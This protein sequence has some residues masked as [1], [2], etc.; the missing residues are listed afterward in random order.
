MMLRSR[1]TVR[2]RLTALY[3][4]LFVLSAMVLLAITNGVGSS[5][6]HSTRTVTSGG[7]TVTVQV[8]TA[9]S[10]QYLVGS[11]IALGVMLVVSVVAGWV[12]AGRVLRPLRQMTTAARRI[13]ASN[14]HERLAIDGPGDELKHL[15]DTIDALLGRL[16]GAF[17]AQ[18]RFVA[19]A[20]HELRTPL[21]TM[22][23]SLDVAVA[24]PGPVPPET[25]TLAGQVRAEL[26]KADEL[27][28]GLLVLARAPLLRR[29]ADNVI[30][31]AVSHNRDGGW[32]RITTM[33]GDG[34]ARLIIENGGDIL[35]PAQVAGLAQPFR[36]LGADR[37]GS[38]DGAGLGLS[39]VAAITEAHRG[40]LDLHAR[41]GGGLKVTITLPLA[42][43]A[44]AITGSQAGVP[45]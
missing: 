32:I 45:A 6:S 34:A 26:N 7:Q 14:L 41:P 28:E 25:I 4:I 19:N 15:A 36:R 13:S 29:M 23:V 18:R 22:R 31:N 17:A 24:K 35:D 27:L 8:D 43:R 33:A 5:A 42:P 39:I 38:D 11:A 1:R 12:V 9:T 21:A 10:R 37:T 20:S 30:G 3:C 2:M 40:S 44:A 16:D